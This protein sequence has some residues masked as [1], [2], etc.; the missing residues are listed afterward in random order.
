MQVLKALREHCDEVS[1]KSFDFRAITIFIIEDNSSI[2]HECQKCLCP[3]VI[4][5]KK[6]KKDIFDQ[7]NLQVWNFGIYLKTFDI[8]HFPCMFKT[9]MGIAY[10]K[11]WITWT[12][13]GKERMLESDTIASLKVIYVLYTQP[14]CEH[15][16]L[17][18]CYIT[19][20]LHRTFTRDRE[21]HICWIW[22]KAFALLQTTCNYTVRVLG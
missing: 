4:N 8:S 18:F 19:L 7:S 20:F 14:N 13:N 22:A 11:G 5:K 15:F 2:Q 10:G 9:A 3:G 21:K 6:K 1:I 17:S 12:S 16:L